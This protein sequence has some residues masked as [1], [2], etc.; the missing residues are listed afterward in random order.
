[1]SVSQSHREFK[2]V[3]YENDKTHPPFKV[4]SMNPELAYQVYCNTHGIKC[5]IWEV[6]ILQ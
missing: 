6:T 1:M 4:M 3:Q 5:D 2:V